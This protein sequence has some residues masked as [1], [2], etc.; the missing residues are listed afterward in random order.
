[1]T[2]QGHDKT[3]PCPHPIIQEG[4]HNSSLLYSIFLPEFSP[5]HPKYL[6][7]VGT[8]GVCGRE[9]LFIQFPHSS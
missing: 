5:P 6:G 8:H 9:A 3:L 7:V 2:P 1:M 4:P